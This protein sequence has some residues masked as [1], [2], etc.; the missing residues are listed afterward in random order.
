MGFSYLSEQE[1]AERRREQEQADRPP[2]RRYEL[3]E[4]IEEFEYEDDEECRD[5]EIIEQREVVA[6]WCTIE[7]H[8]QAIAHQDARFRRWLQF[9][10]QLREHWKQFTDAGGI[11]SEDFAKW[12]AGKMRHRSTREKKHLRL[13]SNKN[14][15]PIRLKVTSKSGND[16]A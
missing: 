9:S 13:I 14:S 16:A 1:V 10:P 12:C 11:S 5:R 4:D 2:G 15:P 6:L 8:R 3:T 7:K